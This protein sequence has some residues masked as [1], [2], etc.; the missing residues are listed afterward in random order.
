MTPSE[1]IEAAFFEGKKV[2][3]MSSPP[4]FA[5]ARADDALLPS[6]LPPWFETAEINELHHDGKVDAPSGTALLTANRMA[7][8]ASGV[9]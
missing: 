9:G 7:S 6:W 5:I 4:N 8:A 1:S 3:G 2:N